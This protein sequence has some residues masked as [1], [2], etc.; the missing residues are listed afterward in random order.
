MQGKGRGFVL[1]NGS[2]FMI[3]E[4]LVKELKILFYEIKKQMKKSIILIWAL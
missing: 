3:D 4:P 2:F 1:E